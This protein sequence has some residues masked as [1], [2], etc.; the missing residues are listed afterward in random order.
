[1]SWQL[2]VNAGSLGAIMEQA[3]IIR[4]GCEGDRAVLYAI[5][6]AAVES[7][8]AYTPAQRK[9]WA[10]DGKDE[11]RVA[12][13]IAQKQKQFWVA[14]ISGA[15]VGFIDWK[16]DENNHGFIDMLYVHPDFHRQNI[17][18]KLIE[19]VLAAGQAQHILYF[20]VDAS[21][22]AKAV[23]MAQGFQIVAEQ[24]VERHEQVLV[25]YHMELFLRAA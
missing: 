20:Y 6:V 1:M 18:T 5:F 14:E 21:L 15:V 11:A 12:W 19:A 2:I 9:A 16:I 4:Q 17:A 13:D 25:N 10:G 8:V 23:F 3:H 24:K 7:A 22:M